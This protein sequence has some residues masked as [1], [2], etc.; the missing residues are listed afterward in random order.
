MLFQKKFLS[1][2]FIQNYIKIYIFHNTLNITLEHQKTH[3]HAH[4]Q[5]NTPKQ[6][7]NAMIIT[8]IMTTDRILSGK[9]L[10]IR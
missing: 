9:V 7:N 4:I 2:L 6:K 8:I 10:I 3:T 1:R 5:P